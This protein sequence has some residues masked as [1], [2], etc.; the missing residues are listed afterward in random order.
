MAWADVPAK[1][2][3]YQTIE[4]GGEEAAERLLAAYHV[5]EVG[6]VLVD[7]REDFENDLDYRLGACENLVSSKAIHPRALMK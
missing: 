4:Y 2:A 3:Q 5:S 6:D 1:F 7:L